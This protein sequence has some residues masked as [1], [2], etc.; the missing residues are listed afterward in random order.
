MC[1]EDRSIRLESFYQK[2]GT[3]GTVRKGHKG[4][5]L[6]LGYHGNHHHP[7]GQ[8]KITI[9]KNVLCYIHYVLYF[10]R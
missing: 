4:Q 8:I 1:L 3:L 10:T 6:A 9:E 7:R 2:L 5:V